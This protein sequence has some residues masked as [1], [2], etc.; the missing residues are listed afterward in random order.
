[1]EFQQVDWNEVWRAGQ[2][3]QKAEKYDPKSWD[4]R[5]DEFS[6]AAAVGDYADQ[7]LAIMQ[8]EPDW[9]VLDMGCAVGTLAVPLAEKVRSVTAADP[10]ERMR[11]L[12]RER[13]QTEGI[14]NISVVDGSWSTSWD[15]K[16]IGP[17]DVVVGSRSLLVA[18]LRGALLKAQQFARKKVFLSTI[19]G[20]GPHNRQMV[21]AIG[22]AFT[23]SADYI[24]AVNLLRQLGIYADVAFTYHEH[25][26]IYT[27]IDAAVDSARWML[28]GMNQAEE[29]RLRSY[30]S[31]ALEPCEGGLRYRFRRP[32]R[33]AVLSWDTR[34]GC[35]PCLSGAE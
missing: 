33:W 7:F 3:T 34:T 9:T 4:K 31:D 28:R 19:V 17:H 15:S 6:R 24:V 25:R 11:E 1:M 13:C 23:P 27:D 32:V 5:A 16:D 22:R 29:T 10:S 8:P 12:L 2:D 30:L 35:D 20:D 21:E 18:D 14:R 26:E